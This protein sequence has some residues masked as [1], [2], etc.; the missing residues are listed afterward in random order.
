MSW[1]SDELET[2][3]GREACTLQ[4][5]PPGLRLNSPRER[6]RHN[7]DGHKSGGQYI[8]VLFDLQLPLTVK[9][10]VTFS[11]PFNKVRGTYFSKRT[12][13]LVFIIVSICILHAYIYVLCIGIV[14]HGHGY[15]TPLGKLWP[16]LYSS[17][18]ELNNT[19]AVLLQ[20]WLYH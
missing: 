11:N 16:P 20:V 12:V 6:E 5:G 7:A 8:A 9:P 15:T 1:R 10:W 3:C 4:S 18:Y 13:S 14:N 2:R 19:T 17:T